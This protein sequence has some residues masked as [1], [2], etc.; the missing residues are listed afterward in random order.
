MIAETWYSSE[1]C[2]KRRKRMS[3]DQSPWRSLMVDA[4]DVGCEKMLRRDEVGERRPGQQ[5]AG[6]RRKCACVLR[7]LSGALD[8]IVKSA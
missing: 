8:R 6:C 4:R 3:A 2:V 5:S 7:V 1:A